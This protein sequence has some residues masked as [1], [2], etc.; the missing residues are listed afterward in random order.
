MRGFHTYICSYFDETHQVVLEWSRS[1]VS[2]SRC[3]HSIR[4][5]AGRYTASRREIGIGNVLTSSLR[6][7][8]VLS[9][10]PM[11]SFSS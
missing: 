8:I 11:L 2:I 9:L 7:R 4:L 3:M 5:E 1:S 6:W 10:G